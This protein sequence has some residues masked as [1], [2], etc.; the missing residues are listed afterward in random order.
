M[1]VE[2]KFLFRILKKLFRVNIRY[3]YPT[4]IGLDLGTQS[5]KKM[6]SILSEKLE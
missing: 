4:T 6:S 3:I 1:L 2:K 5:L